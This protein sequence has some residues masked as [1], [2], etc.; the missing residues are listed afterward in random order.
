[1]FFAEDDYQ[2][3]FERL[4]EA[5]ANHDCRIH[6]YVLMTNHFHLLITPMTETGISKVMQS[7]GRRYVQHVN[8]NYQRTGTLWEGRYRATLLDSERY[9]L[10]F[11]RYI[12]LNRAKAGGPTPRGLPKARAGSQLRSPILPSSTWPVPRHSGI[13]LPRFTQAVAHSELL[14]SS[15]VVKRSVRLKRELEENRRRSPATW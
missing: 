11:Q 3:Y 12:E 14:A 1:M 15:S 7:L 5:C 4:R 10:R 13:P 8:F 2:F 6:A 9:L